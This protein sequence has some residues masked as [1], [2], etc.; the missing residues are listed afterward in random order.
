MILQT[1]TQSRTFNMFGQ[2]LGRFWST[3]IRGPTQTS[4]FWSAQIRWK[5]P[6]YSCELTSA[7]T[8][9]NTHTHTYTHT[10]TCITQI[11]CFKA[12]CFLKIN[13]LIWLIKL[14]INVNGRNYEVLTIQLRETYAKSRKSTRTSFKVPKTRDRVPKTS[15]W[16]WLFSQS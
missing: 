1:T 4:S 11:L 12:V 6:A 7:V 14:R 2:Y 16:Q 3:A 10:R 5:R 15:L 13:W 9:A 8:R